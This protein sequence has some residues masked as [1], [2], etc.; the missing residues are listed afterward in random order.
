MKAAEFFADP[1]QPTLFQT[2]AWKSAWF[3]VWGHRA[4]EAQAGFYFRPFPLA[5]G[6]SVRTAV[7]T[8][9]PGPGLPSIRSEYWGIGED[10]LH[11]RLEQLASRPWAQCLVPDVVGGSEGHQELRHWA[12]AHDY[13]L[14]HRELTRAYAVDLRGRD[15]SDYL[16]GLSSVARR[17]LF[18]RRKRFE[19]AG[20]VRREDLWPDVDPFLD[21][22]NSFHRDR[23]GRECFAGPDR[24]F[25][26]ALLPALVGEGARVELEVLFLKDQ[27]VSVVLDLTVNGRLHNLQLG[28]NANAVKGV[29][30]G[31]VHLGYRI[32][33]AFKRPGVEFYD[34]MAG[35]GKQADYKAK[36]TNRQCELH[37]LVIVRSTPVSWLYEAKDR[38]ASYRRRSSGD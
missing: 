38:W 31:I 18:N 5:P 15:F 36:I 32:E 30:I 10:R 17:K 24:H 29:A 14:M 16:A 34:M 1:S 8:G 11:E 28:F 26:E 22:I 21:L 23:F 37:K 19:Q 4:L 20:A 2:R 33:S 9:C 6:L 7:P 13:R 3:E 25:I 12:S 35:G 27:P